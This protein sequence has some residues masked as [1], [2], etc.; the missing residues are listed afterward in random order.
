MTSEVATKTEIKSKREKV[1]VIV[2]SPAKSKTIKKS[3]K[4]LNLS[5]KITKGKSLLKSK[6]IKFKFRSK[7]YTAKTNSKGIAKVTVKRSV[8]KKL[9][10]GGKY[11]V[12]I[13]YLKNSIK[14]YVKV[15]K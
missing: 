15:K 12:K 14:V 6:K 13:S 7:T 9:K 4:K 2:E 1:L 10:K 5:V 11:T 8:I 3:T